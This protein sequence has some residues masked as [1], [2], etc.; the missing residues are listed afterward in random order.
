[1][2]LLWTVSVCLAQEMT[3]EKL[4]EAGH[5]K[6]AR[7][8]VERRLREAPGD[9]NSTFLASQIYNAFGDHVS[10][11][12]LAE[13]AVRLDGRVARYHRQLAEVQGVMAQH[14]NL[15]Q[16]VRFARRFRNEIDAALELDPRDTQALRDL[17]EFYLLAPGVLGGD[18]GKAAAMAQ[19]IAVIDEAAGFLAS[20]R[21]A[22]FRKDRAQTEAMMRRAAEVR[23]ASYKAQIALGNYLASGHGDDSS[24]EALG[25]AAMGLD[26]GR[27]EAY[28]LLAEIYA[29]RSDWVSLEATLSAAARAVPDDTAPYY[30]AAGLLL[31]ENREPARAAR[32]LRIYVAQEPEGNQPTAANAHA[33]LGAAL[34]AQGQNASV[35]S[36]GKRARN[37]GLK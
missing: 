31:S 1:M 32:Y 23:P 9:P 33:K 26:A 6:R 4:I 35:A 36:E 19:Q 22:E 34:R 17:L 27:I 12:A 16:Q 14:A 3:A 20:A 30:H 2:L 5:W 10:P 13:K 8:L 24:A 37:G 15:F 28:C 11:A 29:G 25:K 7:V 21:I 18:V